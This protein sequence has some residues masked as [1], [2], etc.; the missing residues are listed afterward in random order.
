MYYDLHD[1]LNF[2][3]QSNEAIVWINQILIFCLLWQL[4]FKIYRIELKKNKD[5]LAV[6]IPFSKAINCQTA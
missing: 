4:D 2:V 6:C 3:I 1:Q 5:W